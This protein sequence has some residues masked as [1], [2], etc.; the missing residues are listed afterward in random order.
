MERLQDAAADFDT[1]SRSRTL[2]V[3]RAILLF[4]IAAM[5]LL[6]PFDFLA[7][8]EDSP[9]RS[10]SLWG[11]VALVAVCTLLYAASRVVPLSRSRL[12]I[13][14]GCALAGAVA[15]YFLGTAGDANA[16]FAFNLLFLSFVPVVFLVPFQVRVILTVLP[17]LVGLASFYLPHPQQFQYAYLGMV[18]VLVSGSVG[19]SVALGHLLYRLEQGNFEQRREL[20]SAMTDLESSTRRL[21]ETLTRYEALLEAMPDAM[22]HLDRQ[23]RYLSVHAGPDE[24]LPA[25]PEAMIG[26]HYGAFMPRDRAEDIARSFDAAFA[27]GQVQTFEYSMPYPDGLRYF[28]SRIRKVSENEIVAVRRDITSRHQ[29][30][31]QLHASERLAALGKLSAGIGHEV[32]NPLSYVILNLGFALDSLTALR[33]HVPADRIGAVEEVSDVLKEARIGAGRVREIVSSLKAFSRQSTDPRVPIQIG[34][35]VQSSVGMVRNLIQTR[36]RLELEID[37]SRPVLAT[38]ARLG[39]VLINLL[40]NAVHAIPP[41]Q[42]DAHVIRVATGEAG[43]RVFLQVSDSGVGMTPDVKRQIFDPFFTTKPQGEGTGLGLSITL[44]IVDE[45]GGTIEVESTHGRGS[46]FRVMLPPAPEDA[47]ET[48]LHK[49]AEPRPAR[50]VL[51]IDDDVLLAGALARAIEPT[52]VTEVVTTGAEAVQR[53]LAGERY[54]AILCDLMMPVV[55]GMDVFE[56]VSAQFPSMAGRFIFLT[57]GAFT[58]DARD[59][60]KRVPNPK[61]QKPM[62]LSVLLDQID[63][64]APPAG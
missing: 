1:Y 28:E 9:S 47:V 26:K 25:S 29:L 63:R 62:D 54:D 35:V 55:S 53:L 22:V 14:G 43:G 49:S 15:F 12:F 36:A 4:A 32:N 11:R 57:G 19:L 45:L 61:L 27:T 46:T 16:P 37:A 41:G 64:L 39:Q 58:D 6:A 24:V 50:R 42:P 31:D 8:P 56:R 51:I 3:A 34:D 13:V 23:G 59:F 5:V 2:V 38:E 18:G 21:S 48:P 20:R 52:H 7:F 44:G 10:A 17:I 60:L 33:E 30:L 40:T